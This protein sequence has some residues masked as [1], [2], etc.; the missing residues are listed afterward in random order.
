MQCWTVRI[1]PV[2]G[3][4]EWL[5]GWLSSAWSYWLWEVVMSDLRAV[6]LIIAI[7]ATFPPVII[8][9]RLSKRG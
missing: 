7:L 4:G 2:L 3:C 5:R 6:L 9:G 1:N 8:A